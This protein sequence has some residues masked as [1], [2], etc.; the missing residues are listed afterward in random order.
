MKNEFER[1]PGILRR[2]ALG[3]SVLTTLREQGVTAAIQDRAARIR[4]DKG[5][6]GFDGGTLLVVGPSVALNGLRI[7]LLEGLAE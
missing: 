4:K 3:P 1:Q 5:I 2:F 7:K 6:L